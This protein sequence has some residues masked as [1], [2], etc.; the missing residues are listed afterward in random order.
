[1]DSIADESELVV[2]PKEPRDAE[3]VSILDTQLGY[4]RSPDAAPT[5]IETLNSRAS[6]QAAPVACLGDE[7]VGWIEVSIDQL[8]QEPPLALI[9]GLVVKD[10]VRGKGIG[11]RLCQSAEA[12]S[13]EREVEKLRVTSRSTRPD[14]HRFYL[15]D[16]H[17]SV[18]TS[19]VFEK[20]RSA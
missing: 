17:S 9:G 6:Q 18:K 4:E 3:Q 14:A 19:L 5:W 7:V 11:Q 2:R 16:G 8:V 10:D 20:R 12:W 1:M 15:R 13:W